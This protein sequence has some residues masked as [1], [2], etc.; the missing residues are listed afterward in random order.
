M[1]SVLMPERAVSPEPNRTH[2]SILAQE[3]CL[4]LDFAHRAGKAGWTEACLGRFCTEQRISYDD[5][6]RRWPRG[7]RSLSWELNR[8]ADRNMLNLYK[9]VPAPSMAEIF[10]SRFSQ[11]RGFKPA[12]AKLAWSDLRHPIDTL[13]RTRTTADHMWRCYGRQRWTGRLGAGLDGWLVSATYALCVV[14]WLLDVSQNERF[15]GRAVR[16]SLLMIGLR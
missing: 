4:L 15:T 5:S 11:N 2:A 12:I 8:L 10:L 3:D 1:L 14:V 7:V 13:A 16:A 9:D 6:K